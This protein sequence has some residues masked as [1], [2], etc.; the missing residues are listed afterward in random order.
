ML[1]LLYIRL[2]ASMNGEGVLQSDCKV[3]KIMGLRRWES[4]WGRAVLVKSVIRLSLYWSLR[5][6]RV[7]E[8]S[9]IRLAK[10]EARF[11]LVLKPERRPNRIHFPSMSSS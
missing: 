3:L 8:M 5:V 6:F 11:R 4:K 9:W 2:W 10:R 1:A 7:V